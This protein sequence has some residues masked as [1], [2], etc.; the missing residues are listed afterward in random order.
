[1][2]LTLLLTFSNAYSYIE[3]QNDTFLAATDAEADSTLPGRDALTLGETPELDLTN[4]YERMA[5]PP[6]SKGQP[7]SVHAADSGAAKNPTSFIH[8]IKPPTKLGPLGPPE[9]AS[10][11]STCL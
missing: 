9:L 6:S 1:M 5:L 10:S 2:T 11:T 4:N 7:P 8:P 3:Q